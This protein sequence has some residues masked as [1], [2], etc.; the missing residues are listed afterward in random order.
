MNKK[1]IGIFGIVVIVAFILFG[2][3]SYFYFT[4]PSWQPFD[5]GSHDFCVRQGYDSNA[6][7]G[8]YS[9]QFGK[10]RCASCYNRECT[11]KEFNTTRNSRGII[12]IRDAEVE[13][14]EVR[15]S[16]QRSK[17]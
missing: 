16:K 13:T 1:A 4:S 14:D 2:I 8:D 5:M 12:K 11:Y 17:Q 15:N 7:F 6:L 10:V 3:F 9:K